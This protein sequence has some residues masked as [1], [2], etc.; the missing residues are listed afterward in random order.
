M[1]SPRHVHI[2][3][4]PPELFRTAADAFVTAC[5]E[6]IAAR[7]VFNA[8]LAGGSTPKGLYS[9]LG[10]PP[11]RERIPWDKVHFFFGDERAVPPDHDD[12]NYRMVWKTLLSKVPMPPWHTH[13]MATEVPPR[14][15]AGYCEMILTAHFGLKGGELPKLDLALLG[16]GPDGHTASLFPGSDAVREKTKLCVAPWVEKFK[17]FR[18][19]LTPPVFNNS[20]SVI[21]LVAGEDKAET[22]HEVLEG[23]EDP[24]RFPAQAI[25]PT[26]GRLTWMVDRAAARLLKQQA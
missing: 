20:A 13:R 14:D 3:D 22:L 21:F 1:K 17:S 7:G 5:E 9:L 10:E 24:D 26:A 8:A 23:P 12:N 18:V 11:Y 16:M 25:R 2:L 15:A 19:T 4:T 6:A